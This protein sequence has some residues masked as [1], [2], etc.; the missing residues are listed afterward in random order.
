MWDARAAGPAHRVPRYRTTASRLWPTGARARGAHHVPR[1]GLGLVQRG[2]RLPHRL[3]TQRRRG[4]LV[5]YLLACSPP[6]NAKVLLQ[7]GRGNRR[8]WYTRLAALSA[9]TVVSARAESDRATASTKG[10][11]L[12]ASHHTGRMG[13]WTGL[14]RYPTILP[15][16]IAPR[17]T[18]RLARDLWAAARVPAAATPRQGEIG[19]AHKRQRQSEGGRVVP[20]H[21][22]TNRQFVAPF[23]R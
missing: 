11:P 9:A 22:A 13:R 8:T 19:P 23:A 10:E 4:G 15:R 16:S 21:L 20:L 2:G 12:K 6:P 17:P 5:T 1:R 3:A 18:Q 14:P 7:S